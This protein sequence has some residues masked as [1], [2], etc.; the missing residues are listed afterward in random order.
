M[1]DSDSSS[2][3]STEGSTSSSTMSD[4]TTCWNDLTCALVNIQGQGDFATSHKY[5]F[6]SN[7]AI[8][9]DTTTVPLPLTDQNATFIK[10]VSQQAPFGKGDKTIVDTTIRHTWELGFDRFHLPNPAW[11]P[12]LNNTILRDVVD[13]LDITG[14]IKAEPHKL[15]LYEPGS[16]FAPHKDSRKAENMIATLV[17]CLPS[18]HEGGQVDLSFNGKHKTLRTDGKSS[19]F[20][21]TA[22]AWYSDVT[23]EVKEVVSGYRLVLTYKIIQT[24][25]FALSA[26]VFDQQLE[27]VRCALIRCRQSQ[28]THWKIYPLDH[29]YSRASLSLQDLKGRDRAICRA[30]E[31]LC[32]QH[33]FY[34]FLSHIRKTASRRPNDYRGSNYPISHTELSLDL[35]A[36]SNGAVLMNHLTFHPNAL[37]HNPYG[38]ER[39]EDDF[40]ESEIT[41]NEETDEKFKYYDTV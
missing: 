35:V 16:F 20:D 19:L 4:S 28:D 29:E 14:S 7:P 13:G 18:K 15:L 1:S 25:G 8:C 34:F 39:P 31:I 11:T 41:D 32:S 33:G 37:L 30:L 24:S 5:L 3:E 26:G 6:H 40:E 23:H 2:T 12:F 38:G 17:V 10:N 21:I 36:A 9:I 27:D 22:M